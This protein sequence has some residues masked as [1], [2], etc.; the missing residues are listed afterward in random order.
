MI[1]RVSISENPKIVLLK[2]F[3]RS[4]ICNE[5]IQ[6]YDGLTKLSKLRNKSY[7]SRYSEYRKSKSCFIEW[8]EI[9]LK[10]FSISLVKEFNISQKNSEKISYQSYEIDDHY[11]PHYDAFDITDPKNSNLKQR[12]RT[13]I[14]Y[15]NENFEGGETVF[16]LLKKSI[17]PMTGSLL[18]FE[19]C[20]K[21]TS[22]INPASLHESKKLIS[23]SKK[24]LTIWTNS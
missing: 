10:E 19:N 8:N 16:P 18:I 11:L 4:D 21:N 14:I 9:L 3:M 5:I 13:L 2:N 22:F 6:K 7:D 24:I 23:G 1:D 15:L 20:M 12:L 17:K